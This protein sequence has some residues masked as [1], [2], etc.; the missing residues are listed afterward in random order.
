MHH[1]GWVYIMTNKDNSTFYVGVTN[2]PDKRVKQH[3]VKVDPLCFTARYNLN[4]LIYFLG[5][6]LVVEAIKHEK[7]LKGKGRTYKK[8]LIQKMN[9]QWIDLSEKFDLSLLRRP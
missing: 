2:N 7:Y 3:K 5:F 4:K 8:A 6:D 9:P 1:T